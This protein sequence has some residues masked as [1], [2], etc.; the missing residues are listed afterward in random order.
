MSL[1]GSNGGSWSTTYAPKPAARPL[2]GENY[3]PKAENETTN[4]SN[5]ALI[6]E[7]HGRSSGKA[8]FTHGIGS[9]D[10]ISIPQEE[11][12]HYVRKIVDLMIAE[13]LFSWQGGLIIFLQVMKDLV[14]SLKNIVEEA[15]LYASSL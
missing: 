4:G 11:M 15:A 8:G 3:S 13:S 2:T 10:H 9:G 7:F 6:R 5:L 1:A 14:W 12:E